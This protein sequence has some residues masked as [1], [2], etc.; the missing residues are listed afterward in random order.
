MNLFSDKLYNGTKNKQTNKI[1]IP[2][3]ILRL[4]LKPFIQLILLIYLEPFGGDIDFM[5][6]SN[7]VR[8][9]IFSILFIRELR[10][11]YILLIF[12][13]FCYIE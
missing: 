8:F 2:F 3:I 11:I 5:R 9:H 7:L 1:I 6:K 12:L 4:K 10:L 13:H